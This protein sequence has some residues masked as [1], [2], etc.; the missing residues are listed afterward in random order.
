ML[1]G[2]WVGKSSLIFIKLGIN[3]EP[4]RCSA[5]AIPSISQERWSFQGL[6]LR[7]QSH[8]KVIIAASLELQ[9]RARRTMFF[10]PSVYV[11]YEA[12]RF[13]R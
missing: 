6:R 10:H 8:G 7:R 5:L 2:Q 12:Y 1:K 4:K 3:A 13:R 11:F 9:G